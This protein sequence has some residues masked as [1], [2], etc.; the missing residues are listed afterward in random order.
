V[1]KKKKLVDAYQLH[2]RRHEQRTRI[3]GTDDDE[4]SHEAESR[5]AYGRGYNCLYDYAPGMCEL[6]VCFVADVA[7][8]VGKILPPP[9]YHCDTWGCRKVTHVCVMTMSAFVFGMYD[10]V[11]MFYLMVDMDNQGVSLVKFIQYVM[12]VVFVVYEYRSWEDDGSLE[13]YLIVFFCLMCEGWLLLC[14]GLLL[15]GRPYRTGGVLAYL[16]RQR[17]RARVVPTD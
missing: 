16:E 12:S 4:E 8:Q 2:P 10:Q 6:I 14:E 3:I 9:T 15:C 7:F 5:E 1:V 11:V 13:L 17:A